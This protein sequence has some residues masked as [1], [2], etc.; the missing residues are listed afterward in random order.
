MGF[1]SSDVAYVVLRQDRYRRLV[2][3]RMTK[4]KPRL[5]SGEVAIK[6]ILRVDDDLFKTFMPEV[7]VDIE[8]SQVITPTVE[9]LDNFET[10]E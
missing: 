9:V 2:I 10:P 7:T 8:E 6:L 1:K 4:K 3:D 5:D